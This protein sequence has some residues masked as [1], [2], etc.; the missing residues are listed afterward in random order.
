[1]LLISQSFASLYSFQLPGL[2]NLRNLK[3]K[4]AMA[5]PRRRR[6]RRRELSE[7]SSGNDRGLAV[8]VVVT[9]FMDVVLV[10]VGSLRKPPRRF[11]A[12]HGI[13]VRFTVRALT[14]RFV[15]V[16]FRKRVFLREGGNKH[17]QSYTCRPRAPPGAPGARWHEKYC[18]CYS[19]P[20]RIPAN[21]FAQGR[22]ACITLERKLLRN[23]I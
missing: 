4:I 21:N 1:V 13:S 17:R 18:G 10:C 8:F 19:A 11:A 16:F 22:H 7:P 6:P 14:V 20:S 2:R 15:Y 23:P 3:E 9:F 5:W 12:L